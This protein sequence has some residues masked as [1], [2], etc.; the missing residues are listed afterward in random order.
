[1]LAFFS[2]GQAT[3]LGIAWHMG[4]PFTNFFSYISITFELRWSAT[5]HEKLA[6]A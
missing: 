2:C 1:M 3:A 4:R 6:V 5:I